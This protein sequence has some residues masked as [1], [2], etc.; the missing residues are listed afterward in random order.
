MKRQYPAVLGLA[1]GRAFYSVERKFKGPQPG[2]PWM[3]KNEE[4][5]FSLISVFML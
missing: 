1:A 2:A 4:I 3:W 5:A